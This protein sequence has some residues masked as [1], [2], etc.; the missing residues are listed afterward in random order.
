M[1]EHPDASVDSKALTP[2]PS[3]VCTRVCTSE[4]ENINADAPEAASLG[5]PPQAAGVLD[6]GHRGEGE[7]TVAIDQG[8]PLA[9]LAAELGKLSPAD[10]QRLAALLFAAH[11]N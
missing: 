1:C 8:D 11:L 5:T 10:R 7:A 9:R 6:A 3:P 4:A 2:P